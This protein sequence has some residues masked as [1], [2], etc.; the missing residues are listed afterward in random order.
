MTIYVI[1][2]NTFAGDIEGELI[3]IE[4]VQPQFPYYL[5][6][7][8]VEE[9]VESLNKAWRKEFV[10]RELL[11]EY[12]E[13]SDEE[14][15]RI[16]ALTENADIFPLI[17]ALTALTSSASCLASVDEWQDRLD[18]FGFIPLY[19]AGKQVP[20]ACDDGTDY[21]SGR[22]EKCQRCNGKGYIYE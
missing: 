20:C 18:R 8:A 22:G 10:K 9:K 5:D 2:R 12:G 6:A 19:Q 15:Q 1:V 7:S 3:I 16:I 4:E 11:E 14:Q 13:L 21:S 17:D